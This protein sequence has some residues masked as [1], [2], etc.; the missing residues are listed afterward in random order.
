MCWRLLGVERN[1][2]VCVSASVRRVFGFILSPAP[3][4]EGLEIIYMW[5]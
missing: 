3:V 1:G 5:F 2:C 4:F